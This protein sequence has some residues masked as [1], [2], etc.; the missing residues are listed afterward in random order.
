MS[1]G[2]DNENEIIYEFVNNKTYLDLNDNL[3]RVVLT[4]NNNK[5]PNTFSAKKY[6]GSNKADLSI[7][8]DEKEYNISV[9][10]GTGNS[11]HQ[12]PVEDFI[13]FLAN[14]IEKNE[15][16]F[17]DL[18]FFIWGDGTYDGKAPIDKRISATEIKKKYPLIIENIQNYFNKHVKNLTNRFLIDG[19][20]SKNKADFLLYGD[21]TNCVVVAESKVID[22][23]NK[24]IKKP[25]SIGVLSFQAWNRNLTGIP[26]KE[27]RRGQIQIKW[28]T[29]ERD[30]KKIK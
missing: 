12:E 19:S 3:K 27:K 9:K 4:I 15:S 21:V 14:N 26:N 28:G 18:R 1:T 23:V 22:F 24:I 17:N 5:I 13:A 10:K 16:V 8:I 25:I 20:V 7:I 6:G 11:L 30:L 2:F 29:L